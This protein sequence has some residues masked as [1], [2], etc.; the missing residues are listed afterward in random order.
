MLRDRIADFLWLLPINFLDK[1]LVN[2]LMVRKVWTRAHWGYDKISS[3]SGSGTPP[4]TST[5]ALSVVCLSSGPGLGSIGITG[6]N[7]LT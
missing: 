5:E 2:Q 6:V 3:S 7:G 1:T 4:G